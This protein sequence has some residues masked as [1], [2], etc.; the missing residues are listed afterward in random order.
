MKKI[1]LGQAVTI[2]ANIGVIA[3]I[4]FLGYEMRQNTA[5]IQATT[6]QGFMESS[7]GWL[8]QL[9]TNEQLASAWEKALSDPDSLTATESQQVSAFQ[10]H[11]WLR[12]Q[13]AYFQHNRGS[14]S[15]DEWALYEQYICGSNITETQGGRVESFRVATFD[16]FRPDL[17]PDFVNF[18]ESCRS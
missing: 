7:L 8:E 13:S 14:L 17:R 10:M 1:D 11:Q 12:F 3:G 18:V 6:A 15:D 16:N 5:A 4:V 2:L 9:A